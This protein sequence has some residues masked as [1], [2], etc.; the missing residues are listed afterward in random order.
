[1]TTL[2]YMHNTQNF[3]YHV[4]AITELACTA[5]HC[6]LQAH[7]AGKIPRTKDRRDP[8]AGDKETLVARV[9]DRVVRPLFP[10]GYVC[11]T[12]VKQCSNALCIRLYASQS[13]LHSSL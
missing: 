8:N 11:E 2:A 12:Q 4:I 9:I 10:V 6:A 7:A 13:V 3:K 5:L 1:M